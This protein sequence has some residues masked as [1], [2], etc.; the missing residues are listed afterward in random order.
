M[1]H[2]MLGELHSESQISSV[3]NNS[4]H[5]GGNPHE[6]WMLHGGCRRGDLDIAMAVATALPTAGA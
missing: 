3:L 2:R 1:H 5:M 4:R 6:G